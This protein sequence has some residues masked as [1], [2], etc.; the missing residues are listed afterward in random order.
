MRWKYSMTY[1]TI[2]SNISNE[3]KSVVEPMGII[4]SREATHPKNDSICFSTT[5]NPSFNESK[6]DVTGMF[7]KGTVN[8]TLLYRKFNTKVSVDETCIETLSNITEELSIKLRNLTNED[9]SFVVNDFKVTKSPNL[10][11]VYSDGVKDYSVAYTIN[12]ERMI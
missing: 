11:R 6:A 3:V 7:I 9:F 5:F 12:Y 2:V 10:L 8:F 1:S 4:Y